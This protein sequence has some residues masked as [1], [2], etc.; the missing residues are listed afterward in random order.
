MRNGC[1]RMFCPQSIPFASDGE[2]ASPNKEEMN[3]THK[4]DHQHNTQLRPYIRPPNRLL[5][6][7]SS[8]HYPQLRLNTQTT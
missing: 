1:L 7:A 6:A 5:Q 4:V 3:F 2:P 8:I